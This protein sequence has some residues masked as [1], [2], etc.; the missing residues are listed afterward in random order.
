MQKRFIELVT[1]FLAEAGID[2][3]IV[4]GENIVSV[5]VGELSF[6]IG[7]FEDRK[8]IVFQGIV[9][10]LPSTDRENFCLELLRMN[11]LFRGTKGATLGLEDDAVTLQSSIVI[12][13]GGDM[14][15]QTAFTE[16]AINFLNAFAFV[17]Q[18]FSTI[19]ERTIS[20]ADNLDTLT[21]HS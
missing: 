2:C 7:L 1:S 18:D 9:G 13:A 3:P 21:C 17:L 20:A 11:S 19:D 6:S 15:S 8:A 14:L 5:P 10:V 12:A 4:P 16:Q